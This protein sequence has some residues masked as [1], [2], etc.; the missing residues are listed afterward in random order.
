MRLCH[1]R[2][3]VCFT[4][5]VNPPKAL[6]TMPSLACSGFSTGQLPEIGL[7]RGVLLNGEFRHELR[8]SG[9]RVGSEGDVMIA[10]KTYPVTQAHHD[11]IPPPESN[12]KMRAAHK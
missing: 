6:N 2:L 3:P 10:R 9:K 11:P 7:L 12:T 1:H 8:K 4:H 5:L